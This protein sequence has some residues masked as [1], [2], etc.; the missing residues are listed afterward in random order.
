MGKQ[1]IVVEKIKNWSSS[2]FDCPVVHVDDYLTN[3]EF[4]RMKGVQVINLCR[5]YRYLSVG[6]YCSLLAE[7]RRHKVIPSVKTQLDLSSK[8]M[9]SLEVPHLEEAVQKSFKKI[10]TQDHG[11][12]FSLNAYFGDCFCDSLNDLMRRVFESFPCPILRVTFSKEKKWLITGVK[13]ISYE[14]LDRED[15][16]LFY[17]AMSNYLKKRWRPQKERKAFRFDLAILHDPDD[18]QPPSNERALK[19]LIRAGEKLGIHVDLI[20]RKDFAKLAEYDGLFIRD[21][22]RIKHYTYRF[23]KKAESEG[24]VVI[25]DPQSILRCANKVYLAELLSANSIPTPKT[26]IVGKNDIEAAEAALGYPLVVKLPDGAFSQGV[27]KV[28]NR[29]QFHDTAHRLF[30]N[31]E[32]ILAQEFFYTHFD[33]RI[34]ILNKKPLYACKYFMSLRHWQIVQYS[35]DGKFSEGMAETMAVEDAP[36]E[37]I[38]AALRAAGLIGDGLYGVDLKQKD[39][40]VFIIEI[41]DNPNIDR[42]VEDLVLKDKLYFLIMDEFL[43]RMEKRRQ[44]HSLPHTQLKV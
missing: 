11:D 34:G 31:S 10:G 20:V 35:G 29:E 32:L 41:N 19:A 21:T 26:V 40:R 37:V 2:E 30:K 25:D 44:F 5:S 15:K 4:F 43:R 22:T 17:N 38:N 28:E 12:E 23:A 13:A 3:A 42:G 16:E 14:K 33:W 1:I 18:I 36:P 7:A 39:D 9:Y 8:N 6:Y 27:F 24:M